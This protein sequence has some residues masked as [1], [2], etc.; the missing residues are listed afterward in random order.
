M[1]DLAQKGHELQGC[2]QATKRRRIYELT[3]SQMVRL[4]RDGK[5]AVLP[6]DASYVD[7]EAVK[8]VRYSSDA[9]PQDIIRLKV[10]SDEFDFVG[11]GAVI[12]TSPWPEDKAP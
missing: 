2:L 7:F 3:L 9:V 1:N 12:P 8:G 5:P 11:E 6:A 10:D 4:L